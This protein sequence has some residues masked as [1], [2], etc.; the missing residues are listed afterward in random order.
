MASKAAPL[1]AVPGVGHAEDALLVPLQGVHEV[2]VRG[3]VDQH[4]V[5]RGNDDL[6]AIR[7]ESHTSRAR[8][9]YYLYVNVE[10]IFF[11]IMYTVY[12]YPRC[13]RCYCSISPALEPCPARG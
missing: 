13:S 5:A 9:A 2:A 1:L 12:I 10:V 3:I 4:A 8:K 11:C 6:R 7:L